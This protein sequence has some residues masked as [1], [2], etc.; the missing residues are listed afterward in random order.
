MLALLTAGCAG[1]DEGGGGTDQAA[2]EPVTGGTLR[3]VNEEDVD[4]WDT[5][6]AY[7]VTSWTFARLHVRT[8]YSFDITKSGAEANVPVP[9]I[10]AEPPT[11]SDDRLTYTFKLRPDVKETLLRSTARS[12]RTT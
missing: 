1:E 2:G 11:V 7:T 6:S 3:V 8:L 12:R 9:D 5:G 10:A 4:Y